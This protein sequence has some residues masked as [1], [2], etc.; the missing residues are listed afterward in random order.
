ML[1][2]KGVSI[3]VCCY[4][5]ASR[6]PETI[7]HIAL[8]EI[9]KDIPWELIVVNNN[10]TDNTTTVALAEIQKYESLISRSKI[11]D[12]PQPG[13]SHARH[14]GVDK[15]NYEYVIFC[16]DDNWLEKKYVF[17][18]Y[19]ILLNNPKIAACGGESDAVSDVSFPDWW[20]DYKGGYAV[21]KQAEETGDVTWRK[22]LWGAGLSFKKETYLEVSNKFPSLLS[23]R[24]GLEL[25]SGGDSELCMRL[26]LKGY[27]LFYSSQLNFKHFISEDR[28]TL[29]YREKLYHSFKESGKINRIYSLKIEVMKMSYIKKAVAFSTTLVRL[30][31]F[32]TKADLEYENLKLYFLCGFS[33]SP[34]DNKIKL[35]N[36]F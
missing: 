27:R 31:F 34:L 21:G 19:E 5:S 28:L 4:N 29:S 23:D 26:I 6:L 33:I 3:I 11:V 25:T 9:P 14:K 10:S 22:Y 1:D 24:N 20:E 15:A 30:I 35:I 2:N 18:A 13:L 32:R 12:E 36:N 16:D 8:Q 7:K 17:T